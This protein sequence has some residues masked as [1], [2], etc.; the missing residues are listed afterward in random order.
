MPRT[1]NAALE[2]RKSGLDAIGC[3]VSV[4]IDAFPILDGLMFRSMNPSLDHC[5]WIRGEFVGHDNVHVGTSIFLD[6]LRQRARLH[7]FGMEESQFAAALFDA[8]DNFLLLHRAT[9]STLD[10]RLAANIGFIDLYDAIQRLRI[11]FLHRG[12]DAMA[13]IPCRLVA[14]SESP[15]DLIGAH[16]L[17]GL[18]KQVHAQ[19][20][21]PERL[22][23]RMD[24]DDL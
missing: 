6:V 2:Q 12:T 17:L 20:P 10:M 3:D 7:I 13:Q 19:E 16:A 5:A 21:L 4:N 23:K 1:D 8:D 15:A 14:D 9:T 11:D 24:S 22:K 18:A